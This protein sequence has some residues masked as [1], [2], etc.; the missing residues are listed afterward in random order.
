VKIY[1]WLEED[2]ARQLHAVKE[3]IVLH[4][5]SRS[6]EKFMWDMRVVLAKNTTDNLREEVIKAQQVMVEKGIL[7]TCPPPGYV[8]VGSSGRKVHAPDPAKAPLAVRMFDLYDSGEYSVERLAGKLHEEGLRN[9]NGNRIVA[10]RV[11]ELLRDPF[12]IGQI[13]WNGRAYPGQHEPLIPLELFER[14]QRRLRRKA[15][16]RY[17]KHDHLLKGLVTCAGCGGTI[18][19]EVHKGHTY[20]YCKRYRPCPLPA[21]CKE[22]ELEKVLIEELGK[23]QLRSE[24]IAG[25]LRRAFRESHRDEVAYREASLAEL[26]KQLGRVNRCLDRLYDDKLEGVIDRELYGRKFAQLSA[27]KQEITRKVER[28]SDEDIR[29]F[30]QASALFDLSQRAK[31]LYLEGST[32]EERRQILTHVFARISVTGNM[33]SFEHSPIFGLLAK[34]VELTNGSKITR[35]PAAPSR[36]FEPAETGSSASRR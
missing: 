10:S 32:N 1:D 27:E 19:W 13:R 7:P 16:P 12:Y 24:R 31:G 33:V 2:P 18:T 25:W 4:K 5:F 14:V 22:G 3:N 21:S 15:T 30:E 26:H 17:R 34:A 28:Q 23:L 36:I 11:H 35:L 8:T 20:G 29:Y 9:R 6:Q